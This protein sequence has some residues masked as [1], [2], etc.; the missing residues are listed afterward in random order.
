[1]QLYRQFYFG[2]CPGLSSLSI[3][4]L[5]EES[6]CIYGR[7]E[8]SK[9]L[10]NRL[11]E[12]GCSG[13]FHSGSES[14]SPPHSRN[15]YSDHV[16]YIVRY[17]RSSLRLQSSKVVLNVSGLLK[18]MESVFNNL[19]ISLRASLIVSL[20]VR[21]NL[22]NT[23]HLHYAHISARICVTASIPDSKKYVNRLLQDSNAEMFLA[24]KPLN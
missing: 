24:N 23:A 16:H 14:V 5:C 15:M 17:H 11:D 22:T 20:P 13:H 8:A 9:A 18:I 12:G 7:V 21:L 6:L 1:M 10:T 4:T 19:A 2:I 3:I